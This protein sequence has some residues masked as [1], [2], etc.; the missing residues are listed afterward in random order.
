M[1]KDPEYFRK[2][3]KENYENNKKISELYRSDKN[4]TEP[5]S[6]F[7]QRLKKTKNPF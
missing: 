2:K 6:A 4:I 7:K 5:Y 3:A 1:G